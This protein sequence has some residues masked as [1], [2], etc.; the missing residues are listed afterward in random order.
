MATVKK[1]ALVLY[2]AADMYALVNDIEAY[3]QFLPW[4]RSAHT[5]NRTEDELRATIE[6]VKGGV[7]KT[8]TT[9]NRMQKHKMIDLRLLEGPFKRLE[10]YWRFEPLRADASKV[11]LDMEF[12][13]SSQLLRMAVEPVF[14]Q[15]ANSLVDAFCKRAVDLY[16][17]R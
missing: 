16:G 7:H 2:S 1:S 8:F 5:C 14:K 4:C 10:G 11:S 3:P 13:F 6:L 9:S 17:K 15:I 12:E